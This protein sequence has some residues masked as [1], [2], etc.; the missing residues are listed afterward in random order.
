MPPSASGAAFRIQENERQPAALEE[1]SG[2][3]TGLAGADDD[4]VDLFWKGVAL[5]GRVH[6]VS[7]RLTRLAC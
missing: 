7:L 5:A 1:V 6:F 3:K 2:L 4:Y